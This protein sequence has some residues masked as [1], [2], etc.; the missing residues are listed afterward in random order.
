MNGT[1]LT[2]VPSLDSLVADPGKALS[3]P[4]DV[5]RTLLCGLAGVL[6]VLIA[7]SSKDIAKADAPV[8]PERFLTVAQVVAQYGVTEQWLYRH[9]RQLPYS[10]PSRK[11]L[12]FPEERLRKW[13]AAR[14]TG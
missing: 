5:A 10:Q 14:K 2:E 4:P 6:P 8:T 7:Q 13:F 3:L 9:K 1:P 11:V 12:L